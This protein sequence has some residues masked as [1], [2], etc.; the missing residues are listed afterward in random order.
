MRPGLRSISRPWIEPGPLFQK[1]PSFSICCEPLTDRL[2]SPDGKNSNRHCLLHGPSEPSEWSQIWNVKSRGDRGTRASTS[3]SPFRP[4]TRVYSR[5]IRGHCQSTAGKGSEEMERSMDREPEKVRRRMLAGGRASAYCMA[6]LFATLGA[7]SCSAFSPS[8][9]AFG[10]GARSWGGISAV[11]GARSRAS[12]PLRNPAR[13]RGENHSP[14]P[15]HP[16]Q[17]DRTQVRNP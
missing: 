4:H 15:W 11:R 2:C 13:V 6:A 10:S 14:S 7:D 3:N 17:D 9:S 1:R 16:W 12:I 5:R 8:P